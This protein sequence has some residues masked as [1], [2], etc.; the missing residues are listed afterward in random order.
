MNKTKKNKKEMRHKEMRNKDKLIM[1]FKNNIIDLKY[2]LI[3]PFL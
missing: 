1:N 2:L 3:L